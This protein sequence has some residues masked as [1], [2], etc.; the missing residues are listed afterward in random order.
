MV[1]SRWSN[2]IYLWRLVIAYAVAAGAAGIIT[3][4]ALSFIY[5]PK[6][7]VAGLLTFM[8]GV[9]TGLLFYRYAMRRESWGNLRGRIYD[10]IRSPARLTSP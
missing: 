3:F 7:A 2:I 8:A 4:I 6:Y 10:A 9:A 5:A 1:K